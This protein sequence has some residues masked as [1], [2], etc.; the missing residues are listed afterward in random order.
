MAGNFCEELV[1]GTYPQTDW[2]VLA[3]SSYKISTCR[4]RE[5]CIPNEK[6][7]GQQLSQPVLSIGESLNYLACAGRSRPCRKLSTACMAA[8]V[9]GAGESELSVTDFFI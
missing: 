8:I 4:Y 6:K 2:S 7:T 1:T 9:A 5:F 3:F